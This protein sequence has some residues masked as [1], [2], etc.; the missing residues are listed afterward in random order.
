MRNKRDEFFSRGVRVSPVIA[1]REINR[2]EESD[3]ERDREEEGVFLLNVGN[4][5]L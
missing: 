3:S 4:A 5:V 1:I 2:H